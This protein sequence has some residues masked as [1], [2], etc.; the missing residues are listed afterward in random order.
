MRILGALLRFLGMAVIIVSAFLIFLS[1]GTDGGPLILALV[2]AGM[3]FA[4]RK[5]ASGA[6]GA[7]A[8]GGVV[9]V[10]C[11]TVI[12]ALLLWLFFII[13]HPVEVLGWGWANLTGQS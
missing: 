7:S 8:T 9:G 12:G 3:H 13:S 4:G 1:Q 5:L 11:A 10:V 2:G 6:H